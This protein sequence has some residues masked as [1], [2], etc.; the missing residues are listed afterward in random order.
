VSERYRRRSIPLLAMLAG[1]GLELELAGTLGIAVHPATVL[2]PVAAAP[3]PE[4]TAAPEVLEVDD[5]ALARGQVYG[6]VLVDMRTGD[7]IGLLPDRE[8]ATLEAW[9]TVHLGAGII[10]RDQAGNYAEGARVGAPGAIQIAGRWHL[11]HNLA[12]YAEKTVAGHRSC[13]KDQPGSGNAG[14]SDAPGAGGTPEQ[15]PPGQAEGGKVPPDGFLDACGRERRLV[16]RTQDRYAE[17]R[18][19]LDAGESL[20]AISRV[21]GLD[22]K[23]V[24]R[25]ARV[26]SADE[27]LGKATSRESRLD[28]LKPHI[29]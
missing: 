14:G 16:T 7:V 8:A 12:E 26:G 4:V 23:T 11:W 28:E 9:L 13:L 6:T 1:F 3:A 2:R 25:F 20:S 18:G 10:C 15:E 22:R 24:Q 27:L 19:R 17:I 29:C 21:T 5:F